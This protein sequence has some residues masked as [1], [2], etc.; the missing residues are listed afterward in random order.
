LLNIRASGLDDQYDKSPDGR[1]QMRALPIHP[2]INGRANPY[3]CGG[4]PAPAPATTQ[5]IM[6]PFPASPE[7][8]TVYLGHPAQVQHI[9]L[10]PPP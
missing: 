9:M 8:S 3:V 2:L 10:R 5:H 6:P 7:L 1:R 4:K